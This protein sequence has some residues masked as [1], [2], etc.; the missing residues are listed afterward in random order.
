VQI[1]LQPQDLPWL[2]TLG[3]IE[4]AYG[5]AGRIKGRALHLPQA[6]LIER[7]DDLDER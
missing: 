6:G 7:E 1:L 4:I 2:S 3:L 5:I